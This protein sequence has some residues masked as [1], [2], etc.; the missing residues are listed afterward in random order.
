M[1]RGSKSKFSLLP[2]KVQ[3]LPFLDPFQLPSSGGF[4]PSFTLQRTNF[5]A[6]GLPILNECA[7]AFLF[8]DGCYVGI[9][10]LDILNPHRELPDAKSLCIIADIVDRPL[11]R[12]MLSVE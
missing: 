2:T 3:Y 9:S 12:L 11:S 1:C 8:D 4:L 10:K 5:E 7:L 6:M